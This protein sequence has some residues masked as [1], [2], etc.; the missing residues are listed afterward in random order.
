[1]QSKPL[2]V[3]TPADVLAWSRLWKTGVLHSCSKAF[4]GN[5]EGAIEK[6]WSSQFETMTNGE[7]LVDIGTGN[8]AIPLLAFESAKNSGISIEIHGIDIAEISPLSNIPDEISR[9]IHFHPGVSATNLPF[10]DGSVS[11]LTSQYAFEYMPREECIAESKRALGDHGKI[12]FVMHSED[13]LISSTSLVQLSEYRYLFDDSNIFAH[14]IEMANV[15][16]SA[17]NAIPP[18]RSG[19]ILIPEAVRSHFNER[20]RGLMDRL[21]QSDQSTALRTAAHHIQRA[22]RTAQE[23]APAAELILEQTEAI[24]KDEYTRLT[25]LRSATMTLD[26]MRS[27][28]DSFETS[29]RRL[30]LSPM[31]MN[32][33]VR[34]GWTLS[35]PH[36]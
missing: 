23:S 14:A 33:G 8:G 36:E 15:I 27:L 35:S 19:R 9:S 34:M 16:A 25:H 7:I 5:Y 24:L 28:R 17:H 4:H 20:A 21:I 29:S 2:A 3:A 30:S 11:L 18:A 26:D 1:M 31:D 12:S 10:E 13:S 22:L 32:E 6:F